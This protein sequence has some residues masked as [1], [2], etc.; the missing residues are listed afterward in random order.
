MSFNKLA[1]YFTSPNRKPVEQV[2]E[3][4]KKGA[5]LLLLKGIALGFESTVYVLILIVATI[6]VSV[7]LF[8]GMSPLFAM[9]SVALAGIGML[10]HT[11]NN[12][13]MDSFGP[14]ADNASG[15]A[16][17]ARVEDEE[18]RKILAKL[19]EAGNTTKAVTKAIAIASAVLA[20]ISLF[21]S[22][23]QSLG[24]GGTVV[25][26]ISEPEVFAGLLLG[27]AVPFL[28]SSLSIDAVERAASKVI[29]EVREQFKVPGVMEGKT[30][31][32]YAKVVS[33]VTMA[34][35]KEL[36]VLALVGVLAPIIT[37]LI[38]GELAL[39]AFLAGV[40]LV[41]QLL[42]VFMANAGAAWDNA[43]KRIEEGL[44]GGKGSEQHK[45]SVIGDTVGDPLKDTA[46]PALNP[47]IKVINLVSLIFAPLIM[48][49]RQNTLLSL[50]L[51]LVLIAILAIAVIH[52]KRERYSYD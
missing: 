46:G 3:S 14:I 25:L 11:G 23:A 12:V 41:G 43:K 24:T 20:A 22:Y 51:S 34:A 17:L 38:L 40:I 5:A 26:D 18:Q 29:E 50:T 8:T 47:M 27:G 39:G 2:A 33:I 19:D 52:S 45:A 42:A 7:V 48:K 9:Y 37:G 10:T 35:Q 6:V 28:F 32:D 15:I 1:E 31:P 13:S 30:N 4:S 21:A 36:L 44:Y 16:E 49:F